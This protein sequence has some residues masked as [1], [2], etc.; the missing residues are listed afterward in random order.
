MASIPSPSS[1]IGH[2]VSVRGSQAKVGLPATGP[3][4]APRPT[5]GSFLA[6]RGPDGLLIGVVS[7]V[8]AAGAADPG[9][10]GYQALASI[11]LT[12][13]LHHD[14]AGK[15]GFRRGVRAHPA[16]GDSAHI[17]SS[18]ELKIIFSHSNHNLEIGQL[19]QDPSIPACVDPDSLLTKH[20]AVVGSTGVG[21]SSG[22][23]VILDAMAKADPGLRVLVLDSHNEYARCFGSKAYVTGAG[24]LRLPFWLFNFEEMVDVIYGGRP[25]VQDEVD[26]LAELIPLAKGMYQS[27]KASAERPGLRRPARQT[28]F[29]ADSPTPYLLQDL[30]GLIDDRMGKLENRASRMT[31]HRLMGRIEAI[32]NDPRYGFMFENANVGGDTMAAVLTRLFRLEEDGKPI[33]VLRLASL[34]GEAVDAVVCVVLRLAFEFGLWS[35]GALPLL[36]VCEEAHRYASADPTVG[37]A[38]ARRALARA[39][40]EG[41]KYGVHLALVSQRAAELD[42]TIISQCSTL[43]A[44]R[45]TN[46]QD[47]A[48]LRTAASDAAAHLLDV[49]P[50][51]GTGEVI[52]VGEAMPLPTRLTFRTLPVERRPSSEMDHGAGR[53]RTDDRKA[54]VNQVIER[55]RN[56]R[57]SQ[58]TA[59]DDGPTLAPGADRPSILKVG[60]EPA[61]GNLLEQARS[62]IL[63]R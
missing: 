42:A 16:I 53:A 20:F 24:D 43:F 48:L 29:T 51:L 34:P 7:D 50:S 9:Q 44:M 26:I 52:G 13:E 57:I 2:I 55:W 22:V 12:G 1:P 35:D 25:S 58:A 63:K 17:L 8:A 36:V 21:K 31:Y 59:D 10:H 40:K 54:F 37:F 32:K 38:P 33:T 60:A 45:M 46:D 18:D 5:V 62:S 47:L 23:A 14:E 27:F 15:L 3:T 11:D 61:G 28:G 49:V 41:R 6:V 19:S 4:G 56:A 39:A 30:I